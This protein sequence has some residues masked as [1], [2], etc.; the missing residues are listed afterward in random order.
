MASPERDHGIVSGRLSL[1]DRLLLCCAVPHEND[2]ARASAT[3]LLAGELDWDV[4]VQ[5]S[6]SHGVASLL[7]S[8]L[9]D[10]DSRRKVPDEVSRRLKS[11][12]Y[13]NALRA[14]RAEQ[15]LVYLLSR[16]AG[17]GIDAILLKGLYVAGTVYNNV[18]L[19]PTGDIDLLIRRND[20]RA[21]DS[22][23]GEIGFALP[24]GSLP[25]A[26]YLRA[27]F[28]VMYRNASEA[29]SIP[30]EI[31]WGV[32]DRFNIP[33]IDI[34]ELWSRTRPWSIGGRETLALHPEDTLT[35]LCYHADKH[36]CFSRFVADWANVGPEIVLGNNASAELL[37]YAD[38][39]RFIQVEGE[40][41]DWDRLVGNSKRW[42]IDR[43]VYSSLVVT[44]AL[45]GPSASEQAVRQLRPP[46]PGRL[47]SA[48]YRR[49]MASQEPR[50][51]LGPGAGATARHRLLESGLT[52]QFRPV[53]LLDL[54][55]YLFP[56]P[57]RL[58]ESRSTS[59]PRL[60]LRFLG[61]ILGATLSVVS[62]AGF[63]AG[64]SVWTWLHP[65]R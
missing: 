2:A 36:T 1:E 59:K 3:Q 50:Q 49:V 51:D 35:Y 47:R 38:I 61:H 58:S 26:Y 19:R 7:H 24:K 41:F 32:Q 37:W 44:R 46:R 11:I 8:Y 43:S 13:G 33:R 42:G 27:H 54:A 48:L 20:V 52:L 40:G 64:C 22:I 6:I 45:F 9:E 56:D 17:A 62:L 30:L 21:V 53:R 65:N 14:V 16:M 63:L 31:H 55:E 12:Y 5:K 60:Y 4:L 28:H 29:D 34:D 15:Q 39:Q 57:D 23:L 18:A 25:L 10:Q